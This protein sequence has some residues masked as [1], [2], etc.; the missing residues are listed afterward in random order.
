MS[1]K[2]GKK[3]G[4]AGIVLGALGFGGGTVTETTPTPA[5]EELAVLQE[6]VQER[7]EET[8]ASLETAV[9]EVGSVVQSGRV[10]T[11]RV[12]DEV[13][14]TVDEARE[15]A[16]TTIAGVGEEAEDLRD[17]LLAEAKNSL[18]R[19]IATAASGLAGIVGTILA[20][21]GFRSGREEER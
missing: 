20:A 7:Y 15:R 21:L 10:I 3:T 5:Q 16:I 19:L 9:S 1:K 4:I 17:D 12:R 6:Q 8:I 2:L 13:R 18:Q 14:D 11:Q